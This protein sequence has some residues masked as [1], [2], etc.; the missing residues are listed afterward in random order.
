MLGIFCPGSPPTKESFDPG[1][2]WLR[3]HGFEFR[4]GATGVPGEGLHAGTSEARMADLLRLIEDPE[5]DAILCARGGSGTLGL[6]PL[7]DDRVARSPK[8]IIGMSDVTALHLALLQRSGK[9][10]IA[11]P[12]VVQLSK[13]VPEYTAESWLGIIGGRFAPGPVALPGPAAL[14]GAASPPGQ[15]AVPGPAARSGAAIDALAP[16]GPVA[17][18]NPP[19]VIPARRTGSASRTR[20]RSVEGPILP[21]NLSLLV[22]MI[23]TPYLPSLDGSILVLEDI[24]ETPQSLDRMAAHLGLSG[25][26]DRVAGIVLGQFTECLP[27]GNGSVRAE[28]GLEELTRVLAGIGVPMLTGFPHG[29]ETLCC[30]LPFGTQ[31][32]LTTDPPGLELLE[33]PPSPG[34]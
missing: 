31:A 1:I 14:P 29:H 16:A 11:A 30:S 18:P 8:P 34:R 32:R 33:A 28:E 27:H 24:H 21:C 22:S 26:A 13:T 25:I 9:R 17:L 5:V 23:G 15:S 7:I 10:G 2:E 19:S 6:L 12:M 20:K 3:A 4:I